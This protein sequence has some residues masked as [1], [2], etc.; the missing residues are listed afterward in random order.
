MCV[1]V[2][3]RMDLYV[4]GESYTIHFFH[5]FDGYVSGQSSW[6]QE[7]VP[8]GSRVRIPYHRYLILSMFKN[9]NREFYTVK[10][11]LGS[12]TCMCV[13]ITMSLSVLVLILA[14]A[15]A[16]GWPALKSAANLADVELFLSSQLAPSIQQCSHNKSSLFAVTEVVA[17]PWLRPDCSSEAYYEVAQTTFK[18]SKKGA[19]Q[20]YHSVVIILPASWEDALIKNN[21]TNCTLV[22]I[23]EMGPKDTHS[24]VW[25]SGKYW[26]STSLFLHE[27]GHNMG[28][29]ESSY[30]GLLYADL[31]SAMGACCTPVCFNA[32]ESWQLGWVVE[33]VNV[34]PDS[35]PKQV[36]LSTGSVVRLNLTATH[37]IHINYRNGHPSFDRILAGFKGTILMYYAFAEGKSLQTELMASIKVGESWSA[38]IDDAIF[39]FQHFKQAAVSIS[40][41]V[42]YRTPKALDV[43]N[44]KLSPPPLRQPPPYEKGIV[45]LAKPPRVFKPPKTPKA[46]RG[47]LAKL[48]V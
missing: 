10:I 5:L 29:T 44:L 7:P 13:G 45:K 27:I 31:T 25:L 2:P 43:V 36:Q 40:Q 46:P 37:F 11:D 23:G 12:Y 3:R 20:R 21:K 4:H 28:L 6:S 39:Y 8:Q 14:V 22:G 17:I 26:N 47:K 48:D 38:L 9:F 41:K 15:S 35:L 16:P 33:R 24:Y 1:C 32:A 42:A 18:A 34:D 19:L 30:N